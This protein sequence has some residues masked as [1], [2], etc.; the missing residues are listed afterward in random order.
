MSALSAASDTRGHLD[1]VKFLI[2]HGADVN[3]HDD[4]D[5]ANNWTPIMHAIWC[6]DRS[7]LGFLVK[8]GADVNATAQA[9]ETAL[10]I[11][12]EGS[13]PRT[14]DL[15]LAAGAKLNAVDAD[16]DTALT[17]AANAQIS[18]ALLLH[19]ANVR[20]KYGQKALWNAIGREDVA[21]VRLLLDA[22]ADVN[23]RDDQG[24]TPLMLACQRE[25]GEG[26]LP[27]PEPA[28][29][30]LLITSGASIQTKDKQGET[31]M[32]YVKNNPFWPDLDPDG[33]RRDMA[34]I[35]LLKQAGA[36]E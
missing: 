14:V 30:K 33:R 31:A 28:M 17:R 22:G 20:G 13:T 1:A 29:V 3:R 9:D 32:A 36:R 26:W 27:N 11:A 10:M 5:N 2:A 23:S 4:N 6:D 35:R 25:Y 8:S 34:V 18:K 7:V 16:G 21:G 19:G 24:Q 15:L 12:A